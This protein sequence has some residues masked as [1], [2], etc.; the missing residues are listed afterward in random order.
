MQQLQPKQQKH[1]GPA[2][3]LQYAG[4]SDQGILELFPQLGF[5]EPSWP[6]II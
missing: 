4:S 2:A 3:V 6:A 1:R 5:P